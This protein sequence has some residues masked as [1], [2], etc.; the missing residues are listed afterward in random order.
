MI[1]KDDLR[2]LKIVSNI[3]FDK[4]TTDWKIMR[5]IYPKGKDYEY[6]KICSKLDKLARYGLIIIQENSDKIYNLIDDFVKFSK[7]RFIDKKIH[8]CAWLYINKNW[9]CFLFD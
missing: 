6:H 7:I 9:C 5:R 4:N 1:D 3:D 8:D 2:I